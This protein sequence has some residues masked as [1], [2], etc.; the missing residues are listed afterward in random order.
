MNGGREGWSVGRRWR[1]ARVTTSCDCAVAGEAV[2]AVMSTMGGEGKSV[3]VSVVT[4]IELAVT[5]H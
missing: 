1:R 2:I 3:F 5:D 4:A